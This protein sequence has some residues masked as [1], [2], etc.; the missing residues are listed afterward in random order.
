L[1]I[2]YWYISLFIL[3]LSIDISILLLTLLLRHY[4]HFII[5]CFRYWYW[6]YDTYIIDYWFTIADTLLH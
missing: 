4:C 5:D 3:I 2:D 1:I 6:Y